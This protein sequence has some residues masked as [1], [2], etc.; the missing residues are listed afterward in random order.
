MNT[1]PSRNEARF[2]LGEVAEIVS[3]DLCGPAD[4]SV[5]GVGTDT[6][7]LWPG[8]LFVALGGE[9]FDGHAFVPAAAEKA[10]AAIVRKGF[11]PPAEIASFPLV[12][13]EDPLAALGALAR[14]HRARFPSL[15][16]GAITGSNGKTT[17]K[18]LAASVLE[19]AFG[20]TLKTEGNLNNEIGLPLTLLRL[21]E[22]HRAACVEMGMN[23][24]GEIARLTAIARPRAGLVT[25][26]QAV[27][28]SGLGSVEGVARAKGELYAGLDEDAVAVVNADD[29]RM[30]EEARRA[31]R[32]TLSFGSEG[33]DVA[34]HR[35]V[36]AGRG[37]IVFEVRL[38][39]GEPRPVRLRLVGAHNVQN[40]CAA[41]ALGLA[42]GA[43]EEAVVAGIEAARGVSR[44]LQL[45]EAPGG[46]TVLDDC[47][48]ANP[49]SAIAALRTGS[50]LAPPGRLVAVL[51]D[52]LELGEYEERGHEEVGRAA[53]AVGTSALIAFGPRSRAIAR[54]AREGGVAEILETEDAAEALAWLRA[55][56][57]EGDL[58]LFKAS[59][60][61]RLERIADPLVE[62][63]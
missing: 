22:S 34:L 47:Y 16:L 3:G 1:F 25:C 20:E 10:A 19:A 43:P 17:T 31:G 51:G 29:P 11:E 4:R 28:L 26:A 44:R 52:L 30:V 48:N 46:V 57:K 45:R 32:R 62:G 5:V 36:S 39:G 50:E 55:R 60:G 63:A 7:A 8:A 61:M 12:R 37:G 54:A 23:H 42:L 41:M 56:V 58:V 53:A 40:A 9:T 21:D 14:A 38:R 59:R 15:P 27:H 2:S 33:A 24:P 35:I 49:A 13:V 6:R 18:E